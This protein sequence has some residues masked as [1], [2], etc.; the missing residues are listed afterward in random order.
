MPG[1]PPVVIFTGIWC[2]LMKVCEK[3]N[4]NRIN[5]LQRKLCTINFT[6]NN[7][8]TIEINRWQLRKTTVNKYF[9][10][11]LFTSGYYDFVF[12]MGKKEVTTV[13]WLSLCWAN[14]LRLCGRSVFLRIYR[15]WLSCENCI[16]VYAC[17]RVLA[18]AYRIDATFTCLYVYTVLF[19]SEEKRKTATV[20]TVLNSHFIGSELRYQL[21]YRIL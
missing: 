11:S 14:A 4:S 17:M 18:Q 7:S 13:W 9:H 21:S 10:V 20:W 19:T 6:Y 15:I 12:F 1:F 8:K 3:T 2:I 5:C 16:R